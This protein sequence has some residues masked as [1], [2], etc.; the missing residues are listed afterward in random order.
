MVFLQSVP[1]LKASR[2]SLGSSPARPMWQ[3]LQDREL[4][5]LQVALQWV[6][7]LTCR[8]PAQRTVQEQG[9]QGGLGGS[10]SHFCRY[11]SAFGE[12]VGNDPGSAPRG[13]SHSPLLRA[14]SAFNNL[15]SRTRFHRTLPCVL[16]P[17]SAEMPAPAADEM[18]LPGSSHRVRSR[19]SRVF[20]SL[21]S[22]SLIIIP[23]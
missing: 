9:G 21:V 20:H 23:I 22:K 12:E 19:A 15:V 18:S 8:R 2:S 1:I 14:Q 11:S 17:R 3:R 6:P 7:H 5:A 4:R 10:P 16:S 13:R